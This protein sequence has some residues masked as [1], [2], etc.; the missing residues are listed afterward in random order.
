[1]ILDLLP[2]QL[3]PHMFLSVQLY[4]YM[5]SENQKTKTNHIPSDTHN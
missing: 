1:M 3:Y 5:F 4:P 2:V